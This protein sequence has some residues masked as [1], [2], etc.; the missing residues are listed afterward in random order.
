MVLGYL[1]YETADISFN[2]LK[3]GYNS[4]N[5]VYNWYYDTKNNNEAGK[6]LEE[7]EMRIKELENKNINE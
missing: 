7:L 2:V 4:I 6:L 3:I 1:L 5:Y